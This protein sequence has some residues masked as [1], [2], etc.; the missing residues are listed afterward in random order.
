MSVVEG[1]LGCDRKMRVIAMIAIGQNRV[2]LSVAT[3]L[4]CCV[5]LEDSD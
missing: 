5:G 4:V 3:S 2:K 1:M